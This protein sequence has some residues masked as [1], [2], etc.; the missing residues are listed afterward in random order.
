MGLIPSLGMRNLKGILDD[1]SRIRKTDPCKIK[2]SEMVYHFIVW[3]LDDEKYDKF[4]SEDKNDPVVLWKNIKDYCASS[5][6]ENIASNFEKLF[7]I[8]FQASSSS[9]SESISLFLSTLK[10]LRTISPT[11]FTGDMSQGLLD[12]KARVAWHSA[13]RELTGRTPKE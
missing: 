8:Q 12:R 11:L 1:G 10:L 6:A 9:L 13:I 4:V 3:H 5:S 7:S 2:Q